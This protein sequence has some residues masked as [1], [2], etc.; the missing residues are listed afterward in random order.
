MVYVLTLLFI[1]PFIDRKESRWFMSAY[2]FILL[3]TRELRVLYDIVGLDFFLFTS[4]TQII[5][6]C[7][8]ILLLDGKER[9]ASVCLFL[10]YAV[11]NICIVAWWGY[12]PL[13]FYPWVALGVVLLQTMVVTFKERGLIKNTLIL[14]VAVTVSFTASRYI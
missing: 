12:F 1:A 2:A 10:I 3:F 11:Y 5:C 6:M 9:K 14:I 4:Y 13:L 7:I 8:S